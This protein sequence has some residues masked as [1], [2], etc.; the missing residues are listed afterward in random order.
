MSEIR[1]AGNTLAGAE[2]LTIPEMCSFITSLPQVM[3]VN[4]YVIASLILSL[5]LKKIGLRSLHPTVAQEAVQ[6]VSSSIA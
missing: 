2:K 3:D 6:T 4:E 5:L 1:L